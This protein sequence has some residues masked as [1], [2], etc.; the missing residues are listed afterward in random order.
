VL[1]VGKITLSFDG[2][3]LFFFTS[4]AVIVLVRSY[5]VYASSLL[6][7]CSGPTAIFR[8]FYFSH[9]F[10]Q[11]FQWE[12]S[13]SALMKIVTEKKRCQEEKKESK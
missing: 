10:L 7:K 13:T 2:R 5:K 4:D 1:S 11:C 12:K 9:G 8:P 3:A 6:A